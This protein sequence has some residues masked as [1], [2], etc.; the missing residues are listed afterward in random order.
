M[1]KKVYFCSMEYPLVSVVILNYNGQQW[2][3]KFLP[4]CM[5]T[6][7]PAVQWIV[8]DNASTDDSVVYVK[9]HFTDI[10][11]V[12]FETN[13]GFAK[14][15]NDAV[16]YCK[17]EYVVLLN[18]DVEVTP[19]WLEPLMEKIQSN[20]NIAAVQPK[21]LSYHQKTHF[22]YAGACGGFL[23]KY[24][25]PFCRG[26]VFQHCE[27]DKGQ[28]NE[29]IPVFWATGACMLFR[30]SIWEKIGGLDNDFF[31]HMEEI[32]WCWKAQ[33]AGYEI[34]CEPQSTVY[35]VGGGTLAMDNPKKVYLNFRNSLFMLYKNLPAN[36]LWTT[37]FKRLLF[38]GLAGVFYL[39]KG[40][41][42]HVIA[43]IKAHWYFFRK[44]RECKEKRKFMQSLKKKEISL[45]NK[46]IVIQHFMKGKKKYNEI[47]GKI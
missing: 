2:L 42:K 44:I 1:N 14:G 9:T 47:V 25:V 20:P 21:I 35:H 4:F 28:Y 38:D 5:Q 24:G 12:Q 45:F 11:I 31:A 19:N 32:D 15:N 27:E 13:K 46:S 3:E 41:V 23:D 18:S 43:I 6:T 16:P 26:R 29:A 30:K 10:E 22:E 37:I 17:G 36:K 33:L 8:A 40:K 39:S 7:Y 34:Y